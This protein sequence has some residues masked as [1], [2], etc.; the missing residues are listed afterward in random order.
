MKFHHI[1]I[2]VDHIADNLK[3]LENILQTKE[4]S[5][6]FHDTIQHVNVVFLNMGDSYIELI[7]P[8]ESETPVTSFL[9][10]HGNG[11]HHLGF[12]VEDIEQEIANLEKKGGRIVCKP[13]IGFENRLI[14]FIYFDSVPGKLIELVTKPE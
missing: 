7:E 3:I 12:E 14:S 1:G 13:V 5:I 11:F 6:P 9:K 2:V 8:A 4:T 10:N